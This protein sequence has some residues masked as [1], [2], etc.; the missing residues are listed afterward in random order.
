MNLP[1]AGVCLSPWIDLECTGA[2]PKIEDRLI[3]KKGLRELGRLY[4]GGKDPHT[5]L[6]APLYVDQKESNEQLD[7]IRFD[8]CA[9]IRTRGV[10]SARKVVEIHHSSPE[11]PSDV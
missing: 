9:V 11:K 5:P 2:L 10:K 6:T 1:A 3:N 4:L 8:C 7:G